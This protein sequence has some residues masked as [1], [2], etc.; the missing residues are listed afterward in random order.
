[1]RDFIKELLMLMLIAAIAVGASLYFYPAQ[2]NEAQWRGYAADAER[3]YNLPDGLLT[4]IITRETHWRNVAGRHGE[5]GVAQVHPNTVRM[6]CP[7]CTGNAHRVLFK[8]G[9]RGDYVARIQ[10]VLARYG[11][12]IG[13]IDSLFGAQ[14]HKAV[15]LYQANNKPLRVDGIVGPRTWGALFGEF[16]AYPGASIA[17]ALWDPP[18]NIMWAARYLE[19]LRD[20]VSNDPN[21]MAAAYNGGRGN[22]TV[23][24]MVAVKYLR[25]RDAGE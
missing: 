10:A 2:A 13:A 12:Y 16:D 21:I 14:T 4:A 17:S 3:E 19:W 8:Y 20:N 23:R 9:S 5:I 18:T 11:H 25:D 1:M 6:L 24:Y 7:A 15:L 22:A